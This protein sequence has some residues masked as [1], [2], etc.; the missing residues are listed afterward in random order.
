MD[1]RFLVKLE[2]TIGDRMY[3]MFISGVHKDAK[4]AIKYLIEES[5]EINKKPSTRIVWVKSITKKEYK[6]LN[7]LGIVL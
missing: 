4:E 7:K 1:K 3:P 5:D 6:T 2:D